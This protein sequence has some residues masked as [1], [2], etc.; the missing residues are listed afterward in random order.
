MRIAA[1]TTREFWVIVHRWAGLAMAGFLV[2]VGLTGSLLAF[3]TEL[4]RVFAPELFAKPRPN[5]PRLDLATLAD[6]ASALVPQGRVTSVT[7]AEPDQVSVYFE[8]KRDP[9]TGRPFDLGF[10]EFFVDPWTGAELGHRQR[11]NLL[12][13][14]KNVMPFIYELHWTLALGS[15]GQWI[16]GLVALLWTVDCFAGA[17]L[18]LPRFGP[19]FIGRWG[20]AWRVKRTRN[21]VRLN[22]DM[23]RAGGLWPWALLFVF[24]WSSVMMN[25]RP[26]YEFVMSRVFDYHS[27]MELFQPRSARRNSPLLDWHAAEATGKKL[28]DESARSQAFAVGEHLGL[29]YFAATG[30]YLYEAR[31]SR[32]LFE[33]SP[34]GGG[35]FVMFDGNS[36]ELHSL[37]Q[38]T[39][40]HSGNT[41]ESWLYALHMARVYGRTY[42]ILVALLG[43]AVA[44]LSFTGVLV[45]TAKRRARHRDRNGRHARTSVVPSLP[46]SDV[47]ES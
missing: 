35:T 20:R 21:T 32:D 41:I 19:G 44:S 26:V 9:K 46:T 47:A 14:M 6:R 27:E 36:G 42:Q 16:L 30:E 3:N 22:Y 12:E 13:G 37:F 11:G 40:E 5:L 29:S 31:G 2:I 43:L 23:H 33:R 7:L 34:K 1:P 10:S 45:W 28:M 8:P 24:A 4:E 39:G 15:T 25:I 18:T 17:Y 38:P